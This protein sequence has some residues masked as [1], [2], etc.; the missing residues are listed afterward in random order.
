M[1]DKIAAG[2][3]SRQFIGLPREYD[4]NTHILNTNSLK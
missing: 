3:H 1:K 4:S 2:K